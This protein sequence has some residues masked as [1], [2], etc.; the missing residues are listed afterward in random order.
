M[1]E[2]QHLYRRE[3]FRLITGA[4]YAN[5]DN[6]FRRCGPSP[7]SFPWKI[8][9]T[10]T[11]HIPIFM[12]ISLITFPRSVTW[13]LGA[14]ADFYG[15]TNEDG[16]D[17]GNPKLGVTWTPWDSTTFRAAAFRTLKRT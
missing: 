9:S 16:R 15:A 3:S 14:S 4:G 11:H 17:Q 6:D 10:G 7:A 5:V 8:G 13:T 12:S 2:V 1:G